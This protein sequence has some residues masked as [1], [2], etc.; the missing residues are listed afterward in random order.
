MAIREVV[1]GSWSGMKGLLVFAVADDLLVCWSTS[2]HHGGWSA[3]LRRGTAGLP[4]GWAA[5]G[6]GDCRLSRPTGRGPKVQP[7]V[8]P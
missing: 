4:D 2:L 3:G 8:I 7:R 5:L 1:T 6:T